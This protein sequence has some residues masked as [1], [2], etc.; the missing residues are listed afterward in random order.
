[1]RVYYN[2]A[3][4][5]AETWVRVSAIVD[6]PDI[7]T[8]NN[9]FG[10]CSVVLRDFD[11]VLFPTWE[12]RDLIEMKVT[13]DA[14]TPN[15]IFRGYLMNKKFHAKDL[16]LEIAGLGIMLYRQS[17]GSEE[18]MPYILATGYPKTLNANT[19]IDLWKSD[20]AGGFENLDWEDEKWIKGNKDVGLIIKDNTDGFVDNIYWDCDDP[21]AQAGGAVQDGDFES[22]HTFE[23]AVP[24]VYEVKDVSDVPDLVITA[25]MAGALIPVAK[26]MKRL[27]IEYSF[28]TKIHVAGNVITNCYLQIMKDGSP[29]TIDILTNSQAAAGDYTSG[30]C[31]ALP[32]SLKE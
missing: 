23:D 6:F 3:T 9:M 28:R 15:T 26:N 16:I 5:P 1:M 29:I 24:D 22:T 13:D 19:Q 20:G 31:Q 2:S 32:D 17:F 7:S 21:I 12:P 25:T 14:G 18:I 30:W 27:E 11:G 8:R 10:Y 4:P